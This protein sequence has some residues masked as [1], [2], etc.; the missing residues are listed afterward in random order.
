MERGGRRVKLIG[1]NRWR[2]T[3]RMADAGRNVTVIAARNGRVT[4]VSITRYGRVVVGAM[5]QLPFA[6]AFSL[7]SAIRLRLG[8]GRCVMPEVNR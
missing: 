3:G 6:L 2:G 4:R 5:S 8:T 7:A 1:G